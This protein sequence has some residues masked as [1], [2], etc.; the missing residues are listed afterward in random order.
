MFIHHKSLNLV[1]IVA[2]LLIGNA[3][4]SSI[5]KRETTSLSND[6]ANANCIKATLDLISKPGALTALSSVFM[7]LFLEKHDLKL[8]IKFLNFSQRLFLTLV[9]ITRHWIAFVIARFQ[10]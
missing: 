6:A 3:L 8:F 7:K 9:I 10:M 4:S 1:C 5:R 2:A